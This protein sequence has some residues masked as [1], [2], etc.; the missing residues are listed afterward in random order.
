M[1]VLIGN[2]GLIGQTLLDS[3]K[4]DLE[5][6]SKN[7]SE[8]NN[9]DINGCE[10]YLSCL[11]ATKWKVNQDVI[12]DV[13]NI[14]SILNIISNFHYKKIVLFSTIDVYCDSP[15]YSDEIKT[16][17]FKSLNYGSNRYL[18]ELMVS[19]LKSENIQIF[20][21]PA[22]FSNKIKKNVLFDLLNN[23]NIDKINI[24]SKFQWYNLDNLV[25]D[26]NKIERPGTFN[27]FTEPLQTKEIVDLFTFDLSIFKSNDNHQ[28]YDYKTNLT[29]TGYLSS[30]EEVLFDIKRFV[31][32]F[33]NKSAA[34]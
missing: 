9:L 2:T 15:L 25:S 3:I 26:I 7:I 17:V 12:S 6:N 22:L 5:F 31:N 32:E 28:I 23:N 27:L 13:K 14:S 30:K 19:E 18:F 8:L 21:L 29:H 16:P 33:R 24:N 1:K 20:R 10:L 11:P 34:I 4:F